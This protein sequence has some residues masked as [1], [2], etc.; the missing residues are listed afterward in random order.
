MIYDDFF[1]DYFIEKQAKPAEVI[2]IEE[3]LFL[4]ELKYLGFEIV[5]YLKLQA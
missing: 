2:I 4:T 1:Q 3:M 5:P